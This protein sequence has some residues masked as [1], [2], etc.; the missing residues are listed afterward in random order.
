MILSQGTGSEAAYVGADGT[1][2]YIA[3]SKSSNEIKGKTST[4]LI[5][6]T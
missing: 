5:A 2:N 1:I 3:G 6:L 4:A